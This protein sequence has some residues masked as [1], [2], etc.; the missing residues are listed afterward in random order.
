MKAYAILAGG[1]VKGVALAGCLAAAED[2]GIEFIGYGGASAG[3]IVAA[4]AAAEYSGYEIRDM[5]AETAFTQFL[6]DNGE[7]LNRMQE[8]SKQIFLVEKMGVRTGYKF[9]QSYRKEKVLIRKLYENSGL[10]KAQRL[11]TFLRDRMSEK[12]R[13]DRKAGRDRRD[14]PEEFT[15]RDL[16]RANYKKALKI[17][18]SDVVSRRPV[19]FSSGELDGELNWSVITAVRASTSYPFVFEP[20]PMNRNYYADG[21]ISSNLP[22]FLF[23]RERKTESTPILA[24]DLVVPPSPPR[25]DDYR[26]FNFCR[27]L[28]ETSLES[29]D[30]L[31]Q[32][33]ISGLHYIPVKVPEG[34][35]T[36]KFAL[37]KL[38]QTALFQAGYE[39]A[40][41]YFRTKVPHWFEKAAGQQACDLIKDIQRGIRVLPT[42]ARSLLELVARDFESLT[43]SRDIRC[44]I[45]LP[46]GD[47]TQV[48]VYQYG[49]DDD[50]DIDFRM[51]L[52]AGCAGAARKRLRPLFADLSEARKDPST[53]GLTREQQNKVPKN[54][55]A[56][57]SIP[58][59]NVS[60]SISGK[61]EVS[62][63]KLIGTLNVDSTT[64]LDETGWKL[65]GEADQS[66]LAPAV[67]ERAL[68]WGAVFSKLLS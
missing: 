49:M 33:L 65:E 45:M 30:K 54:R 16:K 59:F 47:D 6:D 25:E 28:L 67:R 66:L 3:S 27:D 18:A 42:I 41:E 31:L 9:Y 23:E 43:T 60:T 22:V 13:E 39:A 48:V 35:D 53:C 37:T 36:L 56:V 17:I 29:S 51:D 11:E 57:M 63:S 52:S 62:E 1:G 24:F 44:S 46:V 8:F 2:K 32:G 64:P 61:I 20:V 19:I 38:E 14:L 55:N 12:P 15:F 26:L 58:L 34:I 40:T 7:E 50:P 21:G 68:F 5:M 4:M 10:Y